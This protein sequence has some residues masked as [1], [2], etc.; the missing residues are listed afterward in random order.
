[1][2]PGTASMEELLAIANRLNDLTE[3]I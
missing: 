2:Q 1:V 3:V